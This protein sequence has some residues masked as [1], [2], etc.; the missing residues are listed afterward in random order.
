[1][2]G[3][4]YLKRSPADVETERD[5]CGFRQRLMTAED[6]VPASVHVT[7]MSEAKPHFHKKTTEYYY[8]LEGAGYLLVDGE[9]VPLQAGDVMVVQPGATHHAE[10]EL[11]CLVI[12]I[13]PFD[14]A[15]Q[16]AKD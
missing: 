4:G 13:P 8:V 16:F 10:G 5:I 2:V 6:S 12:G 14:P 7:K 3:K 11:T 15:D 9:R 1:L